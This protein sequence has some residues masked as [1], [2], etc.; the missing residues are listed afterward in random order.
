LAV[1]QETNLCRDPAELVGG[2]RVSDI[3]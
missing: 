1:E 3:V 2:T